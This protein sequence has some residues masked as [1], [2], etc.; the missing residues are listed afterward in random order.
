MQ[1][2]IRANALLD[3]AKALALLTAS[4]LVLSF[5]DPTALAKSLTALAVGMAQLLGAVAL[6]TALGGVALGRRHGGTPDCC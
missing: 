2:Q 1:T 6:L 5:I 4:V 3:I